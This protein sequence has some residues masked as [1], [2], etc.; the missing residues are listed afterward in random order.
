MLDAD[1]F[2]CVAVMNEVADY[3]QWM[4]GVDQSDTRSSSSMFRRVVRVS[5]GKPWP[6]KRDELILVAYGRSG[7]QAGRQA[8]R[9]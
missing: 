1:L 3:P 7:R 9:Q 5:G 6:F 8:G 4:P 2:S